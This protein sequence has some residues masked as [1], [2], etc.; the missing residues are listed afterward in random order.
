[1]DVD[2]RRQIKRRNEVQKGAQR[3][4]CLEHF[5][6]TQW[7]SYGKISDTRD[8]CKPFQPEPLTEDVTRLKLKQ[9]STTGH[10]NLP[11]INEPG[12]YFLERDVNVPLSARAPIVPVRG[13]SATATC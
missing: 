6:R 4:R 13:M 10:D 9:T 1:M 12:S 7:K 3:L 5:A 11:P 8:K 2:S